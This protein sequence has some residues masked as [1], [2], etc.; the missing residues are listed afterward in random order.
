MSIF[1]LDYFLTYSEHTIALIGLL[2]YKYLLANKGLRYKIVL[3]LT[4]SRY[5]GQV[6]GI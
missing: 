4:D 6:N 5:I 3:H 1:K 2:K